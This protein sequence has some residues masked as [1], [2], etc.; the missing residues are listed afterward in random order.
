[1][2]N[3][4]RTLG[5]GTKLNILIQGTLVVV[6]FLAHY[7]V[8]SLVNKGI[9]DEAERRAEISADGVINGMNMLMVTGMISNPEYRR[10]FIKKMGASENVTELRIIRAKQVQDQFGPGL[11]EEQARDDMDRRAMELKKSQF[12]L[13]ED[14]GIFTVRAVVPFIVESD[15]RGTNCL[16]CHHVQAGSVNGAASVTI[17]LTG[18]LSDI[19]HTKNML[20]LGHVLLQIALFLAI[21]WLIGRFIK[22][23]VRLQSKMEAMQLSG[24]M[25]QFVPLE[26]EQGNQDEIGKLGMA[27]NKMAEA[28]SDSERTMKLSAAIYQSNADAIVV[29]DENNLIVD[30]NPAFTRI[31]GYTLN[32]VIGK[33]PNI[34][35]SGKHDEEFYR[36]MWQ[37]I[38]SEGYWQGEILDKSKNGEIRAKLVRITAVRRA[39]GR[40]YR[41]VAQ[42][43]DVTE[44][45]EKDEL[46][47]WQANYDQLTGLP[48]RRLLN[49]RLQH[50]LATRK[51]DE[52]YGALMYLDLDKFK[53]INESFGHGYG[54][55]LLIEAAQRIK[56][57]VQEVDTV[58]RIG[59]DE[60]VVLIEDLGC[61]GMHDATRIAAKLAECMR[62]SLSRPYQLKDKTYLS[63]SSI[64]V[65]LICGNG[66][67]AETLIKQA[68]LAMRQ[69]KDSGRNAVRFSET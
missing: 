63:T 19:R 47:Y 55:M 54:D 20:I 51:S 27:F 44:R 41:H 12:N 2:K 43:T 11:P 65:S 39:D 36:H 13:N 37:A 30:V 21:N 50:A 49:D 40:V 58:A 9:L 69:A 67:V 34:M 59:S 31:T 56:S 66:T 68:N 38:L 7:W 15:C 57:C 10:L 29:T 35:Q 6:L 28:L 61:P 3:W 22:P 16:T 48:N 1:L 18:E 8:M 5:I 32:D 52:D 26:L 4:W 53:A 23:I 45:K 60:F 17:N 46:I 62:A 24:S 25:E 33:N 14:R 42:Y 64:G